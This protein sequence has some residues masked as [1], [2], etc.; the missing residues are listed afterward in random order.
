MGRM[1]KALHAV[2]LSL[3]MA[4]SHGQLTPTVNA[5]RPTEP[6]GTLGGSPRFRQVPVPPD[7]ARRRPSEIGERV[8]GPTDPALMR[9]QGERP[10]VYLGGFRRGGLRTLE[11]GRVL[12]LPGEWIFELAV[13]DDGTL[14]FQGYACGPGSGPTLASLS[15]QERVA[16]RE[17]VNRECFRLP[18]SDAY[19][20]HSGLVRVSC[21]VESRRIDLRNQCSSDQATSQWQAFADRIRS[22]LRIDD[23]PPAEGACSPPN[24]KSGDSEIELTIWPRRIRYESHDVK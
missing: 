2:S 20:T 4:C 18:Y 23:R 22:F 13:F 3:L 7:L 11:D 9:H 14:A 17:L 5:Q 21:S 6:S 12:F 1:R 15:E 24:T 8:I 19:C 16:L 10:I